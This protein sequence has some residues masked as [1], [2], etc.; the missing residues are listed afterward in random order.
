MRFSLIQSGTKWCGLGTDATSFDDLAEGTYREVD[1]CC[2]THDN[3]DKQ[4]EPFQAKYGTFNL[5]LVTMYVSNN[6]NVTNVHPNYV[7]ILISL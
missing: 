2:R 7:E 3:C 6:T 5:G 4:I 1:K